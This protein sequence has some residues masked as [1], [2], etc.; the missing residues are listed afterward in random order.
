M[1]PPSFLESWIG[2]NCVCSKFKLPYN[3]LRSET[4]EAKN[5]NNEEGK[6]TSTEASDSTEAKTEDKARFEKPSGTWTLE[7][8]DT[9]TVTETSESAQSDDKS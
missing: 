9:T 3:N 4:S 2:F 1:P 8:T 5:E 7:T 6:E